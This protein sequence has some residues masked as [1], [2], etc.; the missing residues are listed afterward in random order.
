ML[1]GDALEKV[2]EKTGV[3]ALVDMISEDCGCEERKEALNKFHEQWL[4]KNG[5][6]NKKYLNIIADTYEQVTGQKVSWQSRKSQ[7][8]SCWK[9][10]ILRIIESPKYQEALKAANSGIDVDAFQDATSHVKPLEE[11][12]LKE[13]RA[14]Y[15]KIKANSRKRFLELVHE[16]TA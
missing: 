16:T 3:K 6:N 10:R 15:P 4:N 12:N 11:L 9:G 13:L 2:F 5:R 1:L 14:L 8:P 7:C